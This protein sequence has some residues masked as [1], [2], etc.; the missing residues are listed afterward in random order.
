MGKGGDRKGKGEGERT[1]N[2]YLWRFDALAHAKRFDGKQ[3]IKQRKQKRH[4]QTE[5][6]ILCLSRLYISVAYIVTGH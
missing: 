4:E 2:G 6:V 5:D 1:A 3:A